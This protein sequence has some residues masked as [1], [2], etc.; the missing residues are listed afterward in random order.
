MPRDH[1]AVTSRKSID[2]C[3][4]KTLFVRLTSVSVLQRGRS[5][6]NCDVTV[7]SDLF[8]LLV[9]GVVFKVTG[10]QV[11]QKIRL[12]PKGAVRK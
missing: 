2:G 11:I 12:S 10:A 9:Y 4:T 1:F 3:V 8:L 5:V 7:Q 6:H